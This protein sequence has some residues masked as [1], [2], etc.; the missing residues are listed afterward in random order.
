MILPDSFVRLPLLFDAARLRQEVGTLPEDRW[1]SHPSDFSGNSALLLVSNRG[2]PRDDRIRHPMAA[3]PSLSQSP[4][5]RQTLAAFRSTL[6]RTRLM[7][8]APGATVPEHVDV[9]PYWKSHLRIHIPITTHPGAICYCGYS[10]VHMAA[11][12]AWVLNTWQ[13]HRVVNNS[14]V[15]RVHLVVDTVGSSQLWQWIDAP[16]E[17]P[18]VV[19]PVD[20]AG[21]DV[22]FEALGAPIELSS[23]DLWLRL[24]EVL[25]SAS[26]DAGV[27]LGGLRALSEDLVRNWRDAE[28]RYANQRGRSRAFAT[29]L[30][31]YRG[32]LDSFHG[33]V[34]LTNGLDAS[35]ALRDGVI[36]PTEPRGRTGTPF[37]HPPYQKPIFLLSPPR[38][39]SSALFEALAK[40]P[41]THTL[42]TENHH[43]FERVCGL[44]PRFEGPSSNALGE[45]DATPAVA[46]QLRMELFHRLHDTNGSSPGLLAEPVRLV[47]KTPK[48]ALRVPFLKAVWPEAQFVV[49]VRQPEHVLASMLDGWRSGQFVTYPDIVTRSGLPWSFLLTPGWR[50]LLDEPLDVIVAHQWTVT[51]SRLLD[52]LGGQPNDIIHCFAYEELVEAAA[53]A[54]LGLCRALDLRPP[55]DLFAAP[56]ALSRNT[57]TP[58]ANDKWRRHV[59]SIERTRPI[60]AET[61]RRFAEFARRLMTST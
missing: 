48:N 41:S 2:N 5:L 13:P 57:L 40:S 9:H 25:R 23:G 11:G 22:K 42:G 20:G 58:P 36:P 43:V 26:G 31:Q 32:R 33:R 53:P 7:R 35:I 55:R 4:Y 15:A 17:Q 3:T 16:Q 28:L 14:D 54:L 29:L 46:R 60:W 1:I 6:G 45:I 27:Y 52:D 24:T 18:M 34:R 38:S 44:A 37:E 30:A 8:L 56:L 61:A 49:L 51:V 47:E 21:E 59:E 50:D 10:A 19:A 12:E 39:G